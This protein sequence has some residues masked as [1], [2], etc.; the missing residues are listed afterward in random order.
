MGLVESIA[1]RLGLAVL[2]R[3]SL[4]LLEYSAAREVVDACIEARSAIVGIEGFRISGESTVPD[5]GAIADFS[6]LAGLPWQLRVAQSVVDAK[7][8]LDAVRDPQ[9]LLEI[10]LVEE[11]GEGT[12]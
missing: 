9:L 10:S 7:T 3:G 6:A 5:M 11:A 8:F 12:D 1:R 4:E 2:H